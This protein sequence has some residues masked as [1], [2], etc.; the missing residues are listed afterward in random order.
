M[1]QATQWLENK[2]VYFEDWEWYSPFCFTHMENFA[3]DIWA[4]KFKN[5]DLNAKINIF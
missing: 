4:E 3:K 5:N 1:G 2:I